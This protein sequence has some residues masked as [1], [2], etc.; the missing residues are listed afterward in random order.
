MP[1]GDGVPDFLLCKPT[2][3]ISPDRSAVIIF[4]E[5]LRSEDHLPSGKQRI[6]GMLTPDAMMLLVHLEYL[7]KTF[8]LPKPTAKM[9]MATVPDADRQN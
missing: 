2:V 4:G 5:E 7:Q 1:E 9:G 3:A 6:L 8:S